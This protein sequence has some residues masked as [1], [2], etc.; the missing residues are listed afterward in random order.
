MY[1]GNTPFSAIRNSMN[2]EQSKNA[3]Y[4]QNNIINRD[5]FRLKNL[6]GEIPQ[7]I[8]SVR[9]SRLKRNQYQGIISLSNFSMLRTQI[10]GQIR[11]PISGYIRYASKFLLREVKYASMA[12]NSRCK[13]HTIPTQEL[14][15]QDGEGYGC[16][17][18][19]GL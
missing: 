10:F 11:I 9:F 2:Q 19:I 5:N 14:F 3:S 18:W 1:I 13:Y 6:L 7:K 8:G 16:S 12:R 4:I 17:H 15:L